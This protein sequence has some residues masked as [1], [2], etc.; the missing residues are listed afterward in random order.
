M[1]RAPASLSDEERDV[2][3]SVSATIENP[4]CSP[5]TQQMALFIRRQLR[6]QARVNELA[7]A[8]DGMVNDFIKAL[9]NEAIDC[10]KY[11]SYEKALAALTR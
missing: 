9:G 5:D 10:K 1:E 11:P 2:W 3:R 4:Q 8:L 6:L 7:T